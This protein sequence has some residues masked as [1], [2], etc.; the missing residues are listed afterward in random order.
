VL[1]AAAAAIALVS[2]G[3]GTKL[4][5]QRTIEPFGIGAKALR[6]QAVTVWRNPGGVRK[7]GGGRRPQPD[8]ISA[9]VAPLPIPVAGSA[10]AAE[11]PRRSFQSFLSCR[12][13]NPRDPPFERA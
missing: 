8:T 9:C 6:P 13:W 12:S 5:N 2:E 3:F 1:L 7:E 4:S 10:A 11:P